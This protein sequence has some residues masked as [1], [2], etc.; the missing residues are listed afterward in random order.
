MAL[1]ARQ[2]HSAHGSTGDGLREVGGGS[3]V[4]RRLAVRRSAATRGQRG[5]AGI[6]R[7]A[8]SAGCPGRPRPS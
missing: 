5:R 4:P 2:S 6:I 8:R 7:G 1:P 3:A